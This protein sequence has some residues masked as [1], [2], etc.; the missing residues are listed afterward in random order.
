[1]RIDADLVTL[2]ACETGIG[3]E[4]HGEGMIGL[5]RAFQYAGA[6]SVFASLWR[7]GRFDAELMSRFYRYLRQGRS[8][9]QAL[10][11]AQLDAIRSQSPFAHPF[12]WAAFS[13][14]GDWQ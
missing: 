12:H 11:A 8:K 14:F 6:R 13:L 5:T 4:F 3:T 1:M 2:S 9:D 10:R 7:R